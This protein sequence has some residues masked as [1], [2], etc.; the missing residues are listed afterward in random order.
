MDFWKK[1]ESS[2]ADDI[3]LSRF[4]K[5]G[6]VSRVLYPEKGPFRDMVTYD[7]FG[8]TIIASNEQIHSIL[9][10]R[11]VRIMMPESNKTFDQAVREIESLPFRERLLA[12]RARWM[13]RP[14]PETA[15]PTA[16]RLGDILKP[17]RQIVN[18][19][20]P[21]EKWLLE[22]ASQVQDLKKSESLESEDAMVVNAI[23]KAQIHVENGH[24]LHSHTLEIIN[25][26][27]LERYYMSPQRLGR[28]TNRLGFKSYNSGDARGIYID[29]ELLNR[30]CQRYGIKIETPP[31]T[32]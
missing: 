12:F 19:V 17:I 8:P 27:R 15:N 6:K 16:G 4:E 32:F 26:D 13:D 11:C 20:C 1:T 2:S 21:D 22:F 9:D 7:V 30:L 29:E 5:G 31:L 25:R 24:L 18:A 28:I 3:I 10:T 23:V 14:L